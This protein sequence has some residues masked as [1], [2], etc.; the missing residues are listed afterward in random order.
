MPISEKSKQ[1]ITEFLNQW[2]SSLQ[3]QVQETLLGTQLPHTTGEKLYE[4]GL[5]SVLRQ[6]AAGAEGLLP[7][8]EATRGETHEACQ[9]VA[10]WM[11]AR[12][13]MPGAYHIPDE[14]WITPLGNLVWRA[15]LWS[16]GDELLTV[17]Q[18]AELAGVSVSAVSQWL[19]RG[20]LTTYRDLSEAN[21]QRQ[22][23]VR[24]SEIEKLRK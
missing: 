23:R 7:D 8:D 24:R 5:G 20:K 16:E 14:W 21:P 6:I 17:T 1:T 13:G 19:M 4:S 10:E 9:Q 2:W 15:L 11:W 18:A 22:T 3:W 12:P